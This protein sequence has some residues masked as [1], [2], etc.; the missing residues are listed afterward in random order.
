MFEKLHCISDSG[1]TWSVLKLECSDGVTHRGCGGC[2]IAGWPV[3]L[4]DGV[5]EVVLAFVWE[6]QTQSNKRLTC[7]GIIRELWAD[8]EKSLGSHC[9]ALL[10]LDIVFVYV[11]AGMRDGEDLLANYV[12]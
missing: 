8:K 6:R 12:I 7:A 5:V 9:E 3:L 11:Y 10:A 4:V 2:F 1:E